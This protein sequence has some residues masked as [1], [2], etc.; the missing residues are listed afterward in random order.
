MLVVLAEGDDGGIVLD[1]DRHQRSVVGNA[2][3]A[4]RGIELRSA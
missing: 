2:G 4:G 3:I 1:I